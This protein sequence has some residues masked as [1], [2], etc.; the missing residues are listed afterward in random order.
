MASIIN[1]LFSGRTGIAS[2]GAA[3]AVV[4]VVGGNVVGTG[5]G[6]V[7]GGGVGDVAGTAFCNAV[8]SAWNSFTS[9]WPDTNANGDYNG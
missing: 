5:V 7:I 6:A 3:I 2:H 4:G 9:A 8:S 1:G